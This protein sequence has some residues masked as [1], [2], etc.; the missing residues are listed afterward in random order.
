MSVTEHGKEG[1]SKMI[2]SC[3]FLEDELRQ[4]SKEEGVTVADSVETLGVNLRT[5]VKRLG[6]QEKRE[7]VQSEFL[8]HQEESSFPKELHESLGQELA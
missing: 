2:A 3:G 1:K 8:A 6:V 7:E 4:C 5:R